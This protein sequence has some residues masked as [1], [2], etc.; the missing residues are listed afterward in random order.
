M[1]L[2]A[3]CSN[4]C[5]KHHFMC[6]RSTRDEAWCPECFPATPCGRDEHGEGCPTQV[7]GDENCPGHVASESDPKI[8]G[9]CGIHIDALRPPD[10]DGPD[11]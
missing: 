2:C 10:D 7:F 9:R 5:T 11:E 1:V 6:D 4:E 8:C 3:R